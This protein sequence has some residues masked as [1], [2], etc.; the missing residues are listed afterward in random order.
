MTLTFSIFSVL[1]IRACS[2]LSFIW[3]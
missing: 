2:C 3:L 1:T